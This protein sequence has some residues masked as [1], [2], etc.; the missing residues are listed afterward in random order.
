MEIDASVR[1]ARQGF[2]SSVALYDHVQNFYNL[3]GLLICELARSEL[4]MAHAFALAC[5]LV[6][7]KHL[8]VAQSEFRCYV[9]DAFLGKDRVH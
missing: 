2:I 6:P 9:F 3:E 8:P 5:V 1:P 7:L 4:H